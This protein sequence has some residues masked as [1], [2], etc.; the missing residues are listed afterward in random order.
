M[1]VELAVGK[2]RTNTLADRV[3]RTGALQH[4][5]R[6]DRGRRRRW[7]ARR[8]CSSGRRATIAFVSSRCAGTAS[9]LHRI[10]ARPPVVERGLW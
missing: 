6:G 8:V 1:F 5:Y 2:E 10:A 4:L 3:Y 9:A 7:H